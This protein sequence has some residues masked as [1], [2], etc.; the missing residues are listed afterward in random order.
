[1]GYEENV[2]YLKKVNCDTPVSYQEKKKRE[3]I[4]VLS[5]I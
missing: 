1:M 4:I 2:A 3:N 5:K